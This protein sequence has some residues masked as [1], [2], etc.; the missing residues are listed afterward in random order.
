MVRKIANAKLCT[1]IIFSIKFWKTSEKEIEIETD[2]PFD[3]H[4]LH[5]RPDSKLILK[6]KEYP[7]TAAKT[8]PT[9]V[10]KIFGT[11]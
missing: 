6:S 7:K 2:S 5:D 11:F 10:N 8:N 9:T 3:P 4:E 1:E